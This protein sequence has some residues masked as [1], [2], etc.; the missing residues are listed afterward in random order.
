MGSVIK[1]YLIW[2]VLGGI[3]YF[4]LS[5][6]IIISGHSFELL[7]KSKLSLKYTIYSIDKKRMRTIMKID[8]LREDGIGELLVEMGRMTEEQYEGLMNR[9][10]N[11]D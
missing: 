10:S 2:A 8:E 3:L 5:Y 9:Y 6:H 7:K 1:K 11:E 4:F